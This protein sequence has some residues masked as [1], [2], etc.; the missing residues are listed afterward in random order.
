M[1]RR[2]Y[3]GNPFAGD[4]SKKEELEY[5]WRQEQRDI[6]RAEAEYKKLV[7]TFKELAA[8]R[9][10][11]AVGSNGDSW[12]EAVDRVM[13]KFA[14]NWN[15]KPVSGWLRTAIKKL[16]GDE[17]APKEGVAQP[18]PK[19]TTSIEEATEKQMGYL[20][21]LIKKHEADASIVAEVETGVMTK[22]RASQLIG[23]LKNAPLKVAA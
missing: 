13:G 6:R 18:A 4:W 17:S 20:K 12:Q 10:T 16:Q 2:S 23:L 14:A 22:A 11:T 8:T 9:T 15:Y 19:A 5:E 21:G 3:P 7:K 1:A